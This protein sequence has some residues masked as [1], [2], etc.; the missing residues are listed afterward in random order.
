[1]DDNNTS[2]EISCHQNPAEVIDNTCDDNEINLLNTEEEADVTSINYVNA[3]NYISGNNEDNFIHKYYI[4]FLPS[5]NHED[6]SYGS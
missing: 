1:M 5:N 4:P 2:E 3:N 6:V